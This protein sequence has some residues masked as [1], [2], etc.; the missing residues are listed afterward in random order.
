MAK[1][2]IVKIAGVSPMTDR[3]FVYRKGL[4]FWK[5]IK[6]EWTQKEAEEIIVRDKKIVLHRTTKPEIVG[7][8]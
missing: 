1:Y 6:S 4:F 8:Y 5:F 3:Y 2:K 7:Y